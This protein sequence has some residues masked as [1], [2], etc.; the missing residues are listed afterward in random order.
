MTHMTEVNFGDFQMEERYKKLER[1]LKLASLR[2]ENRKKDESTLRA[3]SSINIDSFDSS[4]N[5]PQGSR[6]D[7]EIVSSSNNLRNV[8]LKRKNIKSD[9]KIFATSSV[10]QF[11]E[12]NSCQR[13][14]LQMP[15]P[16]FDI[17]FYNSK[18]SNNIET[19]NVS[20]FLLQNKC[21]TSDIDIISPKKENYKFSNNNDKYID[22]SSYIH[23]NSFQYR[24]IKIFTE[25]TVILNEQNLLIIKGK[26]ECGIIAWSKPIIRRLTSTKIECVCKH[27][28]QL[29]GNIVDNKCEL[30]DYVRG[31]F[32][33]GF[34]DDWENVY[35]IWK[36]FVHQGCSATFRWPTPI[37]DSDDDIKSEITDI[38]FA[39]STS[40]KNKISPKERLSEQKIKNKQNSYNKKIDS[41]TQTH[42]SDVTENLC[43]NGENIQFLINQYSNNKENYKQKDNMNLNYCDIKNKTRNVNDILNVIVN[44]LT[45]KNCSQEY[46]SKIF[47]ILDCLNYVVS[48][49][50]IQDRSNVEHTKLKQ[51]IHIEEKKNEINYN[52][53]EYIQSEIVKNYNN[54]LSRK[55][56]FTEMNNTSASDSESAIYTGIPKIPIERII[57]Q[58]KTLLKS[59]KR[60]IRKKEILQNHNT[61]DKQCISNISLTIPDYCTNMNCTNVRSEKIDCINF[62]DSSISITEDERDYL[63]VNDICPNFQDNIDKCVEPKIIKKDEQNVYRIH[64][65]FAQKDTTAIQKSVKNLHDSYEKIKKNECKTIMTET[66]K[67]IIERNSCIEANNKNNQNHFSHQQQKEF[68]SYSKNTINETTKPIVL[69]S[70]PIDVEIKNKQLH[71]LQNLK[72]SLIEDENKITEELH[73]IKKR[74]YQKSPIKFNTIPKKNSNSLSDSEQHFKENIKIQPNNMDS[75]ITKRSY[76]NSKISKDNKHNVDNKLT[77]DIEPKLLSD[78]T[79][80]VLFKSGLNL[81]FEGNLLNEIGHIVRRKFK[82]DKIYR[83]VSGKLVETIHHEF[84]Q[85]VG[86]LR[87]TKHVIPKKLL[88]KCRYGCPVNIEQFCK[89][90]ESLQNYI[91]NYEDNTKECNDISMDNI[92]IGRSSKGRRIIPPLTYWTGERIIMKDNNPVYKPG[93]IQDNNNRINNSLEI[94][95]FILQHVTKNSLKMLMGNTEN[96]AKKIKNN[97]SKKFATKNTKKTR[98]S[99][100]SDSNS[101]HNI[102]IYKDE[103]T[104]ITSNSINIS[105]KQNSKPINIENSPESC[106]NVT[107]TKTAIKKPK[108]RKNVE[109]NTSFLGTS[110]Q[111]HGNHQS[112]VERYRD[113]VCMYYQDIPN[114]DDIL[115]DDQVSHV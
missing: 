90:W 43:Y 115:S 86:N 42:I 75:I 82:T 39:Y 72:E 111:M 103:I 12:E 52:S 65:Y 62:N 112:S 105:N 45:D 94:M 78:W 24:N 87:D 56:T 107:K 30:P 32:Y 58:K 109:S 16:N 76:D 49:K 36:M 79:P 3:P 51:D 25:W 29:Q 57:R 28:Y 81:I 69:S 14:Y 5:I 54:S 35:E 61:Q 97:K 98:M 37:T 60:K 113:I 91:V 15:P 41:F 8:L 20:K 17:N 21:N 74:T 102:S 11:N 53:S 68:S 50:S 34:P 46:I 7:S 18:H 67:N 63:K 44:N 40:P 33:D 48:Y 89:E 23:S 95:N 96:I 101:D 85:L 92:N 6:I 47:E 88:R 77:D 59:S 73:E 55:R 9:H 100:S 99:E 108:V 70:I 27:L 104:K 26:I 10:R 19:Y 93:T 106:T 2:K 83:R 38:T 1:T 66:P 13:D 80:R 64:K 4:I 84:Y 22:A 31:K 71:T 114:K 110:K